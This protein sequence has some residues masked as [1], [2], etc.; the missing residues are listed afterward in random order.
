MDN[1]MS[2]DEAEKF[3][4]ELFRKNFSSQQKEYGEN[5]IFEND[6]LME[7]CL[8]HKNDTG[9][10]V[11][12]FA[13]DGGSWK[14]HNHPLWFLMVNGYDKNNEVIPFTVSDNPKIVGHYNLKVN[15]NDINRVISF[16]IQNRKG[17]ISLG[18]DEISNDEFEDNMD[19]FQYRINNEN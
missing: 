6:E 5:Y 2:L 1:P 10:P 16:I 18:N 12:C 13:D 8:L 17:L 3:D 7:Y 11:Y 19:T 4:A 15:R 9:L 14:K